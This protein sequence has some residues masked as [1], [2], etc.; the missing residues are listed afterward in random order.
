MADPSVRESVL[1]LQA[2]YPDL[3]EGLRIHQG[4][5]DPMVVRVEGYQHESKVAL[6]LLR[7]AHAWEVT[8]ILVPSYG[9]EPSPEA[10]SEGVTA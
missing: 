2:D 4:K 8:L 1:V 3:L 10:Q 5:R 6:A 7:C 9:Q